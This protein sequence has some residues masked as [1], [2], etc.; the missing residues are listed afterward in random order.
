MI[1]AHTQPIRVL[2]A[3]WRSNDA[4]ESAVL[5]LL[6]KEVEFDNLLDL[7]EK[8]VPQSDRMPFSKALLRV[9]NINSRTNI[10]A[11]AWWQDLYVWV[12]FN[13]FQP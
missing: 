12:T 8:V 5:S 1:F 13:E 10:P 9:L 6:S 7:L 2:L 11:S 3:K 4:F